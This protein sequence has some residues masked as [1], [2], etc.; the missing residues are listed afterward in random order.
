MKNTNGPETQATKYLRDHKVTYQG[1]LYIYEV[2]GGTK[3]SSL[4]LGVS[5][6][7]VIKTLIME[8]EFERP[9]I[10][11]MHGDYKVSTKELARQVGCKKVEPCTPEVANRHTGFLVGGT[12]PFG[13]K[14]KM[15]I[16][17]ERSILDLPQI[18]INGGRRGFLVSI[19]PS[20]LLRVLDI[21]L[22]DVSN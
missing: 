20:E 14:K 16:Y 11:L 19:S 3:A 4:A 9:M 22:V 17:L 5:E 7:I 8:D 12:S 2:N 15:P 18:Y 21:K 1:H 10:V 6:H 13:T